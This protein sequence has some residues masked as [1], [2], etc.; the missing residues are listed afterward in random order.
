ML[1]KPF[2]PLVPANNIPSTLSKP[3]IA[4]TLE[5][6]QIPN[7]MLSPTPKTPATAAA[8]PMHVASTPA[9]TCLVN[10]ALVNVVASVEETEYSFEERRLAFYV[11]GR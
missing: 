6:N 11:G 5:E 4:S 10:E 3:T 8:V 1:R 2:A 7:K 9:P